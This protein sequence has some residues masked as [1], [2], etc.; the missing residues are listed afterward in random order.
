M[1]AAAVRTV[2][3]AVLLIEP[4]A[5][6]MRDYEPVEPA[7]S[8]WQMALHRPRYEPIAEDETAYDALAQSILRGEGYT[9]PRGWVITR[10]HE[11]TAY[12]GA[13]YPL[14]VAIIYGATGQAFPAVVVVQLILSVGAVWALW[15][16]G[17]AVGGREAARGAGWLGALHPGLA[18]APS[19]LMT[20]ALAIPIVTFMVWL[21]IRWTDRPGVRGAAGLGAL[22]GVGFL[23]RSPLGFMC[24][25]TLAAAAV[26][27]ARGRGRAAAIR[28]VLVG[29]ATLVL[30]ITPW[31]VRNGIQYG[32]FVP[33]DTKSGVNLWM[34]NRPPG[35][36]GWAATDT[37]NEA[38]V[39]RLYR[40]RA[41]ANIAAH[42]G[43]FA[44]TTAMR[45][46]RYWWPVPRRIPTLV[47]GVGVAGYALVTVLGGVGLAVLLRRLP[48]FGA[49]WMV[50]APVLVGWVLMAITAT[51]LRHRLT[52][53]PLLVVCAVVGWSAAATWRK[54]RAA[55]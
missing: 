51:G 9:M 11:P 37:L 47:H 14:F 21:A 1:G 50:V 43:G 28:P 27:V 40:R 17:H 23:V 16:I 24:V 25:A 12:G 53:E 7:P 19:L 10:P 18:M 20:E 49:A 13:A 32:A 55:R 41:L 46:V 48:D 2:A 6:P 45:A 34:Y 52:A 38:Q 39:D 4:D 30:V 5:F 22:A 36:E 54:H 44:R 35:S 31:A 26:V 29:A 15:G 3:A 33:T 42:P 8:R